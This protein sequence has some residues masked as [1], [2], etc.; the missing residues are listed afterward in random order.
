MQLLKQNARILGIIVGVLVVLFV[1]IQFIPVD[2]TNPATAQEPNWDSPH[3]R[4]LAKAACFDC[5]SNETEW[6]WYAKIAPSSWLLSRDVKEG[7]SI[8]NFSDWGGGGRELDEITE[9]I[10]EGEMPPW[11]YKLMHSNAKLSDT[12]KQDL[13]TGLMATF[14]QTA[15]VGSAG[16][17]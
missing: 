12:E 6:P 10:N 17:K 8:L 1:V 16:N 11:Y 7:R 15:N 14:A 9:V 13:I 4:E 2:K 5:H 3:T